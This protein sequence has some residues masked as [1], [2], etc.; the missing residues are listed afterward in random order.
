MSAIAPPTTED[1]RR[2]ATGVLRGGSVGSVARFQTGSGNW[3]FDVTFTEGSQVV[4]RFS[5]DCD[6]CAAAMYWS[7]RLRPLGVPLPRM[8]AS[9]LPDREDG[10]AWTVLE[11]L[12]G[13]DLAQCYDRLVE[14]QKLA[15]LDAVLEAQSLLHALPRGS[16]FGYATLPDRAPHATWGNVIVADLERSHRRIEQVGAVDSRHIDRVAALLPRFDAYFATIQPLAFLDDTT[17]KNVIIDSAG[18][19]SGIVDVDCVCYGDPLLVPALTRMALLSVGSDTFYTDAWLDRLD[20]TPE[21]RRA[22]ELYTAVFCINFLS[23]QGQQFNRDAPPPVDF[24][25]IRRLETILDGLCSR[26]I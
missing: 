24:R 18:Q 2:V 11:R 6:A 15:I 3:A 17:T 1:A 5:T 20:A 22:V 8:L 16:G 7:T 13:V 10:L 4:V 14:Q 26:L 19:F 9:Y 21:Q 23:E 12:P 25:A